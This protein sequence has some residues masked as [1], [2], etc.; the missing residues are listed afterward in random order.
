MSKI[1]EKTLVCAHCGKKVKVNFTDDQVKRLNEG[2]L[3]QRVF[4]K[5][6]SEQREL[7][8]SGTCGECWDKL[9]KK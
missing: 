8:M 1:Y 3:I 9:F 7:L 2:E 4:P 6:T 5:W